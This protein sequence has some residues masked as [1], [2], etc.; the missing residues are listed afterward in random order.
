MFKDAYDKILCSLLA[1]TLVALAVMLAG[2]GA[3][4]SAGRTEAGPD[5]ALEREMAYQARVEFINRLYSPVDTLRRA[6]DPQGALFKLDELLRL[7]PGEAHGRILQGEILHGMGALDEAIARYVEGVRLNGDYVDRK[8]QLSRRSEI[9][10]VADEGLKVIGA[11]ARANPGNRSMAESLKNVNYL[12]S[13]LA[14]G[15]E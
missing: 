13:R 7:N 6:G 10:K 3:G 14:G 15:C 5:K 11:R 1:V 12:R 9:Q 8:S 2:G 4:G